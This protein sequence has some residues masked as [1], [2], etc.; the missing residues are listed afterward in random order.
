M[1]TNVQWPSIGGTIYSVPATGEVGWGSLSN[2]LIALANAQGTTNQKVAFRLATTSPVTVAS[3]TDCIVSINRTIAGPTSVVLPSGVQGQTFNILDGKGDASTNNITITTTGGAT[4]DGAASFVI[5]SN[6][7]AI[8]LVYNSSDNNWNIY[9]QILSFAPGSVARSAIAAATPDWVVINNGLGNLSQE[10]YL[11][12]SRGGLAQDVSLLTGV[13]KGSGGTI[14]ASSIVDADVSAS[15]NIGAT[16][17]QYGGLNNSTGLISGGVLS[18]NADPTKFDMTAGTGLIVT[19]TTPTAPTIN[20]LS[21]GA[22]TAQTVTNIATNDISYILLTSGG[23]ILQQT[24]FPTPQQQRDNIFIGRM[25]HSNRV[26]ISFTDTLADNSQSIANQYQDLLDAIGPFNV[27]GNTISSNGANLT[28]KKA[29]GKMFSRYYQISTIPTNPH[30]VTTAANTPQSFAYRTQLG[31]TTGSVTNIDPTNYDVGG[32]ITPVPGAVATST[33]QRVFLFPSNNVRIQYGQNTYSSLANAIAAISTESFVIDPGIAGFAILIGYIVVQKN[34][35]ALNAATASLLNA[36]RFDSGSSGGAIATT[37]L[38]TAYDISVAPLLT[39]SSTIGTF[40]IRDNAA[41]I[42]VDLFSV[43]DTTGATKYLE[44]DAQ[45]VKGIAF[46]TASRALTTNTNS[47]IA[48]SST[49]ST[50]LALL[51]IASGRTGTV[52]LVYS[53]SP[54]LTTPALGTPS[55]LVLTNAT[56][57]PLNTGVTGTLPITSGGTS[58]TSVTTT[59]T[60]SS[61]A[62][63]D[64]NSNLSAKNHIQGYST[65]ATAAGTTTLTVA[66]NY[67]QYFTGTSTQ[68]VVMPVTSTLVLGQ[69]FMIVN[70]STGTVTVNSSGANVIQAMAANTMLRLTCVL[71]SGTTAASWQATYG[72][73][74]GAAS[75]GSGVK[76]YITSSN[77]A[78]G[79]AVSGAGI[80]IGNETT[81]GNLPDN[82][83]QT[84]AIK[85]TRVSGNTDYAYY[86]WTMDQADYSF[87]CGILWSQATT[88]TAGG[89]ELQLYTNTASNYGGS[90]VQITLPTSSIPTGTTNFQTNGLAGASGTQYM[91]LRI[92]AR[93]AAGTTPLYLNAVTFTPN[94]PAQGAGISR[95]SSV[96]AYTMFTNAAIASP[97]TN[98]LTIEQIGSSVRFRG[99]WGGG[100]ATISTANNVTFNLPSGYTINTTAL[101]SASVRDGFGSATWAT[102]APSNTLLMPTYGTTSTIIFRK[103]GGANLIESDL[104]SNIVFYFDFTLPI[105]EATATLNLGAGAQVQ[106]LSNSTAWGTTNTTA[107]QYG[108]AGAAIT[109]AAAANFTQRVRAQYPIQV[110]DQII[111]EFQETSTAVWQPVDVFQSTGSLNISPYVFR[112][113]AVADDAGVALSRVSGSTTD[114]DVK[115]MKRAWSRGDASA[116]HDW[117]NGWFWRLKILTPSSPVGFG[118]ANTNAFGLVAP[119]KGTFQMTVTSGQAGWATQRASGIYYQD[120]DGNHRLKFNVFGTFTSATLTGVSAA[121]TGVTFKNIANYSQAI[122]GLM[123]A[124]GSGAI[125]GTYV[126]PNTG[127][128]SLS[129]ASS[130]TC[131]G[132]IWS[133]DVE[134]ESRPSWA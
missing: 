16:K 54:T 86:R 10:Q 87:L 56:G 82:I 121:I 112:A 85:I 70:S 62:G 46:T 60:A 117:T 38:Q 104:S 95:V 96:T 106:Y 98:S 49:T 32:V 35:V 28:F 109:G 21:W 120:Q 57:L 132:V 102:S 61:F 129:C 105:N 88:A 116:Y 6:N 27:Q 118:V 15:A 51:D 94:P 80:T 66:S 23:T 55:A 64:A 84:T 39:L 25:N 43:T 114:I 89:Y 53:S 93:T 69:Q 123:L 97:T 65:T 75:S 100:T 128:L 20:S 14:S 31:G 47:A 124:G 92:V 101:A 133:G 72:S 4:I 7:D 50:Q 107:F 74:S 5:S 67:L 71:T 127:N 90:Y 73:N 13:L 130:T 41:P 99:I 79:W 33:I 131:T 2:Y 134:L 36:A 110:T 91:E 29:V 111:L 30:V 22:F 108:P 8:S 78:D 63:W 59:P 24:T 26:T 126:G 12:T 81:A 76:N 52:N 11:S 125:L 113:T 3:S 42:G 115:F 44:I 83:T 19:Y 40:G 103:Q 9:T 48:T 68:T 34:C 122:S 45:G 1:S 77:M 58:V 18:I 37:T 17:I 119:T